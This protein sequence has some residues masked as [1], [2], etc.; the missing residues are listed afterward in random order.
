MLNIKLVEIRSDLYKEQG[1]KLAYLSKDELDDIEKIAQSEF[2][3][4]RSYM[5]SHRDGQSFLKDVEIR[6]RA[7]DKLDS[8]VKQ[9]DI[10]ENLAQRIDTVK[11]ESLDI[12]N[13]IKE[14][15]ISSDELNKFGDISEEVRSIENDYANAT[16]FSEQNEDDDELAALLGDINELD[17]DAQR[18]DNPNNQQEFVAEEAPPENPELENPEQQP[19]PPGGMP[20]I[21]AAGPHGGPIIENEEEAP[22]PEPEQPPIANEVKPEPSEV[23]PI[24]STLSALHKLGISKEQILE[25]KDVDKKREE[26]AKK[27]EQQS[28]KDQ[29]QGSSQRKPDAPDQSGPKI[30]RKF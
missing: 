17:P 23:K 2:T 5:N 10:F 13:G 21:A 9:R 25:K 20:P 29:S 18:N 11:A 15:N 16:Q 19:A 26:E 22:A 7:L 3:R 14:G 30:G 6:N 4:F 8:A 28:A 1:S 24:S 12:V 27:A